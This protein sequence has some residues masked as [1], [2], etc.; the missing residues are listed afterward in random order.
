MSAKDIIISDPQI[1]GPGDLHLQGAF[2]AGRQFRVRKFWH[3]NKGAKLYI[4]GSISAGSVGATEPRY[5][6]RIQFDKRLEERRPAYFPMT[7]RYEVWNWDG[8]WHTGDNK[9]VTGESH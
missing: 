4:L 7:N 5:G 9:H 8:K 2:F 1:T 6:T 3:E